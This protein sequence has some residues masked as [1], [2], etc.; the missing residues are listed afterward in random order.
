MC[1][2]NK[3][4]CLF[5]FFLSSFTIFAAT[6][7]PDVLGSEKYDILKC[8]SDIKQTCINSFCLTSS[9][10]N[11]QENCEKMAQHKCREQRNQ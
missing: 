8:V 6:I 9:Q 2:I 4:L 10:R 7:P 11:C 5:F 1:C 3:L